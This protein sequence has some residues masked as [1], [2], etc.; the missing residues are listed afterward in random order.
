LRAGEL[1]FARSACPLIAKAGW[2]LAGE[3]FHLLEGVTGAVTRCRTAA[4][5]HGRVAVV[6]H[7]LH[8]TL[9]PACAG[10][11]GQ[12]HHLAA[13][14]ADVEFEQVF[15]LHAGWRV[16]LNHHPLQPPGVGEIIG[17]TRAQRGRDHAVDG[18]KADAHG[19][20]LVAV[21]V[22]LQLWRV[23][24]A[25]GSHLGD[26]LALASHAQQLVARRQQRVVTQPG[27]VL[28]PQAEARGGP[29]LRNGRRAQGENERITNA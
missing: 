15:R 13:V 24:Q 17:I 8:R 12:R 11:A 16:G 9:D 7:G 5:A 28:Q 2:Q 20:G 14:I 22:Q 10:K 26:D 25:I 23:F 18:L 29:Q 3:L 1:F 19:A 21:D 27:A 4:D 6:T